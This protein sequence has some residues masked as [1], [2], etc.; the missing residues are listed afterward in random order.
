MVE[1]EVRRIHDSCHK[2]VRSGMNVDMCMAW[3]HF[4]IHRA[5]LNHERMMERQVAARHIGM[6]YVLDWLKLSPPGRCIKVGRQRTRPPPK[7][8]L[9]VMDITGLPNYVSRDLCAYI[10]A[11]A[12]PYISHQKDNTNWEELTRR[13]MCL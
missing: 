9:E 3:W 2:M 11:K 1:S 6:S 5:L 13:L 12:A 10:K 7:A 4:L 8:S